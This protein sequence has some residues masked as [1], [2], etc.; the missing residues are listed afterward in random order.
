MKVDPFWNR[1]WKKPVSPVQPLGDLLPVRPEVVPVSAIAEEQI[2]HQREVSSGPKISRSN[3]HRWQQRHRRRSLN[4]RR[5]SERARVVGDV[6]L[7]LTADGVDDAVRQRDRFKGVEVHSHERMQSIVPLDAAQS[8]LGTGATAQPGA[9]D[10]GFERSSDS[11][12]MNR[13]SRQ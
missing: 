2:P 12:A 13:T 3:P 6:I 4:G 8:R 9:L 10:P 7:V 5:E 11:S 1:C